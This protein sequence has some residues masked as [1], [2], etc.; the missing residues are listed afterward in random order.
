MK[1][2]HLTVLRSLPLPFAAAFG[3]LMFL[4]LLQF[5]I[6]Y[7]PE[8]VGRGLPLGALVELIA[9]S[10]AYM[11]TLAVPIEAVRQAIAG[12]RQLPAD[13]DR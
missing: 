3:T 5:L 8:L 2:L 10:L 4:L 1:K 7:L 12:P 11:V 6:R 9:Y 13:G